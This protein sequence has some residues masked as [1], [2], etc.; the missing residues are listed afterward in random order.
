MINIASVANRFCLTGSVIKVL[1]RRESFTNVVPNAAPMKKS[2]SI[3][4]WRIGGLASA[5]LEI[6]Q[7]YLKKLIN[8]IT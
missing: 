4:Y 8:N 6:L 1:Y 5:F 7:K 3:K 2:P